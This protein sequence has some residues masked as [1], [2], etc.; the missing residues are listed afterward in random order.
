[1]NRLIS[2]KDD[3]TIA[4]AEKMAARYTI[5]INLSEDDFRGLAVIA[6][7]AVREHDRFESC[8]EKK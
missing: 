4:V 1:M 5:G 6:I 3:L 7:E 8:G 2:L